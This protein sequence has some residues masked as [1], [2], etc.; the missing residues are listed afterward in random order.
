VNPIALA[1]VLAA[2]GLHASWNLFAKRAGGGSGGP[3]FVFSFSLLTVVV[4][5]PFAIA[6][7]GLRAPE[8]GVAALVAVVGSALLH[9]GYFLSL[10]R[11]YRI[12]DLSL[13]YPL[14]RGVGPVLATL[15]A[16][17]WLGERPSAWAL[18]GTSLVVT[19]TIILA[20]GR[21][22]GRGRPGVDRPGLDRFGS[23]LAPGLRWGLVTAAFIGGYT[24]WDARAVAHVGVPPLPFMW[25]TQAALTLLLAPLALRR[26]AE[27]RHAWRHHR[28]AVIAVGTLSPLAYLMVLTA[29][30]L[31]PVS[32][33]APLRETSVLIGAWLGL[34]LL[35]EQGRGRRL[36][37]AA[38]MVVGAVLLARG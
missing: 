22:G 26:S 5:A 32:L 13:V 16:I 15:G 25:W 14:A 28:G 36:V 12:G 17:A 33:V 37:A 30:T 20:S 4:F 34:T 38:V 19:A 8:A 2:A 3:A 1:L 18:A 11:S 23:R 6:Q 10:Q 29:F 27:V 31:A 7:G 9:V 24:L 21:S 35:G